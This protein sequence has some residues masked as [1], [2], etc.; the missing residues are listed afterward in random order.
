MRRRRLVATVGAGLLGGAAGCTG[1][2]QQATPAFAASSPAFEA[3]ER[4]PPRFTCDGSGASPPLAV[5][6][7]PAPT[8]ALAVVATA[9]T[10]AITNATFWTLWNVPPGTERIPAGLPREPALPSLDGA[11]QGRRAGES[12]GYKPPCPP[13]GTPIRHRFQ[14]YA[15]DERVA[16]DGGATHETAT[17]AIEATE[18]ASARLTVTYAGEDTESE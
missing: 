14:L 3:G 11:R 18:L 15:L 8:A 5:D 12:P 17:D 7:V 9:D 16:V 10:G 4:L 2:S 6:R 13:A 1:E